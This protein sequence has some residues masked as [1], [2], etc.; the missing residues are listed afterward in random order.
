MVEM[1][2]REAESHASQ[3]EAW[4]NQVK[5]DKEIGGDALEQN[6]SHARKAIEVFGSP[7]LKELL[8]A[9]GLG[10]HPAIIK[11]AVAAG[12][13]TLDDKLVTGAP[14]AGESSLAKKLFPD[15]N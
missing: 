12:K 10:N 4:V 2:Q 1:R 3:V 9:T 13:K 7:E 15:M 8:D 5:T 6:L 14:K 11:F